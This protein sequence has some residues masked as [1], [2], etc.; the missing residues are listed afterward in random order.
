MTFTGHLPPSA[1]AGQLARADILVLPNPA[2]AISTHFTSPLKLFEYMAAGT[3]DRGVGPAGDPRSAAPTTS[4]PLLVTPGDADALAGGI[5][6][7]V[8]DPAL[9]AA[10]RAAPRATPSRS[11]AGIGAP[12]GSR[13]SSTTCSRRHD[14]FRRLL[15]LVR[16]PE[17]RGALARAPARGCADVPAAA[18]ARYQ[19]P[20]RRVS[21]PA[22]GGRSSPSR[23]SI[24]TRRCTPTRGTSASRRR[25]SDRRSA[26]T[27]CARFLAPEPGDRVVDLGCG[28][29][30]ALAVEPRLAA[31]TTVGIDISPFFSA[32]ARARRR[33][34]ARRSAPAAVRR[35]HV[36]Q[37]VVA[38]R[39]RAPVAR[40]AARR[41]SPRRT[42]CSRRAARC[43]STRTS[44]RTRRSPSG[45]RWINALA[46]RLERLGLIDMRQER[47]RKSDHL[48]P[49][50]DVPDLERVARD[51]GFR[52]ARITLLHADRRRLRREHPDARWPS[53]RWR[54]APRAG[55]S[56]GVS[57]ADADARAIREAR[58][59]AKARIAQQPD[60]LRRAARRCRRDEARPA[61]VRP[62]P[63]GTVLRA[64][65]ER[66]S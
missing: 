37:G 47:L 61:A 66:R 46:R 53:A 20:A 55:S 14:D 48:N 9:R 65:G 6:R 28:S 60:D 26:T 21:R 54:G 3:A 16:C 43:S 36:H 2:S 64:A 50:A 51:A 24:S 41:C 32:D 30:R 27:C 31:P 25:C 19:R 34:A 49:L 33:P 11:T 5:R 8:D 18:A 59:A 38:R 29:G 10:A 42:A 17:C 58:T 63:L 12:N 1:V 56:R 62:H 40:G 13:R 52:I 39:A 15:A 4:T 44:A 35:R 22:A 7:L 23:R 57:A 45:L